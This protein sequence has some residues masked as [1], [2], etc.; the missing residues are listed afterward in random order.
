MDL[1]TAA[2]LVLAEGE[3][4]PAELTTALAASGPTI[5][6]FIG[7]GVTAGI[8]IMLAMVGINR[9]LGAFSKT[10]KKG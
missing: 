2:G 10:A 4:G 9:G 1:I 6:G 7:V 5:L 3:F 8:G